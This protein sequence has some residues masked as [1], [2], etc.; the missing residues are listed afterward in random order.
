MECNKKTNINNPLEVPIAASI[1][2]TPFTSHSSGNRNELRHF[3]CMKCNMNTRFC[4]RNHYHYRHHD[5]HTTNAI[6]L[7][8]SRKRNIKIQ[9]D[10]DEKRSSFPSFV[11]LLYLL[12]PYSFFAD[13]Q[14]VMLMLLRLLPV[15]KTVIFDWY[16]LHF[17]SLTWEGKVKSDGSSLVVLLLLFLDEVMCEIGNGD[18]M[19]VMLYIFSF[20]FHLAHILPIIAADSFHPF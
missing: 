11:F 14:Q 7:K 5:H 17:S 20:L 13:L 2:I 10:E 4:K 18:V 19:T 15:E 3:L 6:I 9:E 12:A 1:V 8:M 16:C